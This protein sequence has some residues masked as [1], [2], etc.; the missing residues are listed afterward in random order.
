MGAGG[1]LVATTA[2][3]GAT[4]GAAVGTGEATPSRLSVARPKKPAPSATSTAASASSRTTTPLLAPRPGFGRAARLANGAAIDS[5]GAA[6]CEASE[7]V[8]AGRL[9]AG[10]AAAGAVS[11]SVCILRVASEARLAATALVAG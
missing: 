10:R 1:V 11:G 3:F 6:R 9:V 2:G 7:R 8:V 4:V 5:A